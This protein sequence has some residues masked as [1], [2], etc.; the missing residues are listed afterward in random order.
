M[1][2][3]FKGTLSLVFVS[4]NGT[5]FHPSNQKRH[6]NVRSGQSTTLLFLFGPG[7]SL[8]SRLRTDLP[9]EVA[10]MGAEVCAGRFNSLM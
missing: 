3:A 6:R 7:F 5:V 10:G 1:K 8:R 2:V 4:Q 9:Y